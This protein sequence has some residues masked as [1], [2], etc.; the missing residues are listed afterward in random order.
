MHAVL[1]LLPGKGRAMCYLIGRDGHRPENLELQGRAIENGEGRP[2]TA[3]EETAMVS[4][5]HQ[6][7][8]EHKP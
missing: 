2:F 4:A 7:M 1:S 6:F 3:A 5:L 8:A